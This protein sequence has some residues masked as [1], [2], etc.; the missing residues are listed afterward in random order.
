MSKIQLLDNIEI[1]YKKIAD[2]AI[3]A[4]RSPEAVNLIAV[5]KTVDGCTVRDAVDAGLRHFAENRVQEARKKIT[6]DISR[7]KD[8]GITWHLIGHLQKN[9]ARIAVDLFDLIQTVDT[10]AL[11][12]ELNRQA[13]KSGKI[14]RV[15]IQVSLADEER[16]HGIPRDDFI[17]L[18]KGINGMS[19]L[20]V[21][22]LMTM[23]PFFDDPEM[24]RP[25]FR[26]LRKMRD[27]AE[28]MG[29][30]LPELSMGMSNDFE[31]AILEGATMVRVGTAIFGER[32]K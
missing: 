16:K 3:R 15:L 13:Q 17:G 6:G 19:S 32:V 4:G 28:T 18:L 29:F 14:Q 11:A 27:D 31:V 21:E 10:L 26:E 7:L 30:R 9:K 24:T 1:V 5:T 12:E 8:A 23:P 22:G 25:Y 20:R 2:A